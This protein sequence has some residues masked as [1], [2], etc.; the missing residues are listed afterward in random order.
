[1]V[2]QLRSLLREIVAARATLQMRGD[3]FE[4]KMG[5]GRRVPE[6]LQEAVNGVQPLLQIYYFHLT[7]ATDLIEEA[8]RLLFSRQREASRNTVRLQQVVEDA[9]ELALLRMAAVN[10]GVWWQVSTLT[11]ELLDEGGLS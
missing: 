2:T 3:K 9:G 11:G 5:K 4:V 1:M 7:W 6:R 10:E 8:G